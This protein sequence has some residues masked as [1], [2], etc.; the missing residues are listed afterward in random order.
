[1]A[2]R[3]RAPLDRR[4]RPESPRLA[5][6]RV[7]FGILLLFGW[8]LQGPAAEAAGSGYARADLLAEPAWL[9]ANLESPRIRIVDLRPEEEYRRGHIP[10]AVWLSLDEIRATRRGVGK[11]VAPAKDLERVL[12]RLGIDAGTTVVA[13]DDSAGL[14]AAR[15]YWT[16]EYA[17]HTSVKILNGGLG[18]WVSSGGKLSREVPRVAPKR[19]RANLNPKVL[20]DAQGVRERIGK[21]GAALVDARSPAEYRG[22]KSGS[23]RAGHIPGAVN[24]EWIEEVLWGGDKRWK[25]P[26]SL[27]ALF[28]SKGVTRDKEV[29]V[30]CQTLHRAAHTFFTLRLLGYDKVL[31]YDGSWEEWGNREDLPIER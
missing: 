29:V 10:G 16:L 24:V 22:E 12:G 26:E 5:L 18:A 21:G 7:G 25:S 4:F 3:E 1:M 31:G 28:E 14:N 15:L 27:R 13:Y 11:M 8:V 30:Y 23:R 20:A 9:T 17:G 19:F 6:R 2:N